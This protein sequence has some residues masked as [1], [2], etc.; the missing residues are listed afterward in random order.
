VVSIESA[1][2]GGRVIDDDKLDIQLV[3]DSHQEIIIRKS[4]VT[5]TTRMKCSRY[6][7]ETITVDEFLKRLFASVK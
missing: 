6:E 3:F 1:D 2:V 7:T 5:L 4:E